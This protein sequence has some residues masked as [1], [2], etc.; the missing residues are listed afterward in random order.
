ME[1][2]RAIRG[3]FAK[4]LRYGDGPSDAIMVNNADWLMKLN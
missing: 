1:L 3:V 4:V 2:T